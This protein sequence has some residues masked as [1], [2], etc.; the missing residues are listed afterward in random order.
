MEQI[1]T[2]I[3]LKGSIVKV[4]CKTKLGC[5]GCAGCKS[6]TTDITYIEAR[7]T[8]HAK[9]GDEVYIAMEKSS[10]N[11][12]MYLGYLFP[13]IFLLIGIIIGIALFKNELIAILLGFLF[14]VLTY[15][16][17]GKIF[18]NFSYEYKLIRFVK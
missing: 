4:A 2:I 13:T 9:L 12:M 18:K 11:K 7:N 8:L 14:C 1:G 16:I 6:C 5:G 3:G 15:V 17:T 10:Y